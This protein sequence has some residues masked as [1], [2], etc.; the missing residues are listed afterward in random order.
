MVHLGK[1]GQGWFLARTKDAALNRSHTGRPGLRIGLEPVGGPNLRAPRAFFMPLPAEFDTERKRQ[2]IMGIVKRNLYDP[3]GLPWPAQPVPIRQ[4]INQFN[5]HEVWVLV[6]LRRRPDGSDMVSVSKL[7]RLLEPPLAVQLMQREVPGNYKLTHIRVP[8]FERHVY[9]PSGA[10]GVVTMCGDLVQ[11]NR[12]KAYNQGAMQR[13]MP[14]CDGCLVASDLWQE[15]QFDHVK[16]GIED[17]NCGVE[18]RH[19]PGADPAYIT[20]TP[21]CLSRQMKYVLKTLT[22]ENWLAFMAARKLDRW[23]PL[24]T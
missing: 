17:C 1:D 7:V 15:T 22:L 12:T 19:L 11:V 13:P 9:L 8:T 21:D 6:E 16:R 24:N 4:T 10:D 14:T 2:T 5:G 3:L 23:M 20:C 18:E